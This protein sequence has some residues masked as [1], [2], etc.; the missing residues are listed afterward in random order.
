MASQD[1]LTYQ[2]RTVRD[3]IE[4]AWAGRIALTDFQRSFVWDPDRA[5]SYVGALL[6]G[7]PAGLY[8]VLSA[9]S[10]MPQF[11]PRQ[12]NSTATEQRD[13]VEEL[14]LD[15]QQRLT[16]L[17]HALD[18]DVGRRFFIRFVDL[19]ASTLE[20]KD[21]ICKRTTEQ[22]DAKAEYDLAY[23]PINIL[24]DRGHNAAELTSLSKWC[25]K[26]AKE[27]PSL[28]DEGGRRLENKIKDFA[29]RNFFGRPIWYCLLPESTSTEEAV[30]IFV[31]TNTSSVRIDTFDIEVA[32]ARGTHR[33]NL[34]AR[35]QEA[36]QTSDVLRYYFADDPEK[37]IPA[38]GKWMFKVACLHAGKPPKDSFFSFART[39]LLESDLDGKLSS[40][41]GNFQSVLEDLQWALRQAEEYGSPTD[42]AIPSWPALHVLA[43]LRGKVEDVSD[44][45]REG[46]MRYLIRTYYWRSLF[47][48]RYDAQANDRL[49]D[50][51]NDLLSAFDGSLTDCERHWSMSIFDNARNPLF[52]KKHLLRNTGWIGSGRLGKA[53]ASLVLASDPR[54]KEWITEATLS[55]NRYRELSSRRKLDKHH[56]FPKALLSSE[57]VDRNQ[58]QNGLNGVVLDRGTNLRFWKHSPDR[59]VQEIADEYW[60]GEVDDLKCRIETHLVPFSELIDQ[61]GSMRSRYERFLSKRADLISKR[62]KELAMPAERY[63]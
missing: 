17:L 39:H 51:Y 20:V 56:V 41:M 54:P 58:S 47:S 55:P 40:N 25:I 59:Y 42:G 6:T 12:F 33:E 1:E 14:V 13:N 53:L 61:K 52:D 36:Y 62:V 29:E 18:G 5:A 38:V 3:W 46:A 4:R 30:D 22:S 63:R 10:P 9:S 57:G 49:Y 50:D 32:K 37:F 7:K 19:G 11:S 43:A 28:G 31:S 45:G 21:V 60:K 8:L 26:V 16:S 44:P 24:E 23:L 34:R 15:G 2:Q 35:I 48:N 27:T